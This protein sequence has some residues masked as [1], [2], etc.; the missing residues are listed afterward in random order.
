MKKNLEQI[1]MADGRYC[2]SALQFVYDGLQYTVEKQSGEPGHING[3][4]LCQGLKDMAIE[5]WGRLAMLVL[6][7]WNITCT[8]DFGEI[9]YLMIRNK[10]MSTRPNDSREDFD[11]VYDF[12]TVFKDHF[13]F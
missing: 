9:V 11:N 6:I 2:A 13:R 1:S 8:R 10:W 5:K 3:Q 12:K 4:V 7:S